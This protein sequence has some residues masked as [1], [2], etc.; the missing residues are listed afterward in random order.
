MFLYLRDGLQ[1][2]EFGLDDLDLGG[3]VVGFHYKS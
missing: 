2:V 3:Y 1:I